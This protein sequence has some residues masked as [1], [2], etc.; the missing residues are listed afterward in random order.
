MRALVLVGFLVGCSDPQ[1]CVGCTDPGVVPGAPLRM[2][3]TQDSFRGDFAKKA[4]TSPAAAA[5]N[6][7]TTAA[8]NAGLGGRW[9][10]WLSDGTVNA[11]DRIAGTGP[12]NR[13]DGERVFDSRAQ[14]AAIPKKGL[15][16]DEYDELADEI[17]WTGSIAG[18]LASAD[19]CAHWTDQYK[20]GLVGWPGTP[21]QWTQDTTWSCTESAHLYCFEQ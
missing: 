21:S 6:L 18:G 14:L 15:E 2:F 5:D 4:G 13:I 11:I 7:C 17:V 12:W 8:F 19:D 1:K 3:V 9:R 16:R 20:D 10:A